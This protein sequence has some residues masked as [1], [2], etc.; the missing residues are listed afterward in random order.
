MEI[1]LKRKPSTTKSTIGELTIPDIGFHCFTIEDVNRKLTQHTPLPDIMHTKQLY[2]NQTAIPTGK[3]EMAY[4]WSNKF[5]KL[6]PLIIG[7]P[8]YSGVRIHTGNVAEQSGGC[9]LLGSAIGGDDVVTNS[10]AAFDRFMSVFVT[11][12]QTGKVFITIS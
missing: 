9:V 2:P 6:M 8:G 3:Y 4:T 1:L 11:A 10:H 7:V 5:G 12:V